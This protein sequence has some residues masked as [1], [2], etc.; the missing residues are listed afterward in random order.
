MLA[1]YRETLVPPLGLD[2]VVWG[3]RGVFFAV[4]LVFVATLFNAMA[5]RRNRRLLRRALADRA[6]Q[7]P[8]DPDLAFWLSRRLPYVPRARRRSVVV[9][10]AAMRAT[11]APYVD[12]QL[13]AAIGDL[14][15]SYRPLSLGLVAVFAAVVPLLYFVLWEVPSRLPT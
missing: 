3:G 4:A 2:A 8:A 15:D 9:S 10:V 7:V 14:L 12:D 6:L 5:A 1:F 13:R 11:G